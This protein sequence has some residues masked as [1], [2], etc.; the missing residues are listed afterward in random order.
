[1]CLHSFPTR[2]SSD[3]GSPDTVLP[4]FS[5]KRRCH[6]LLCLP[7]RHAVSSSFQMHLQESA[8]PPLRPTCLPSTGKTDGKI[9]CPYFFV[10]IYNYCLSILFFLSFSNY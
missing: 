3:L 4:I 2:R 5:P 1:R 6:V 7:K 10:V 9:Y 8:L